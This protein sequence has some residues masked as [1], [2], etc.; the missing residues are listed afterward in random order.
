MRR[1]ADCVAKRVNRND[2]S[3]DSNNLNILNIGRSGRDDTGKPFP[4]QPP[5]I[6]H[7]AMNLLYDPFGQSTQAVMLASYGIG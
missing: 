7:D 4:R 6:A 3:D 5:W 2:G 1:H